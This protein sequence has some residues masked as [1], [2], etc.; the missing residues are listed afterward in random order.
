VIESREV[1]VLAPDTTVGDAVDRVVASS[2]PALPVAGADGRYRGMFGEREL[3]VALFPAYVN[4]LGYAAFVPK[5]LEAAL[6][7][8]RG[9]LGDPVERHMNREH[10]DV[11]ADFSDLQLAEIFIHHRVLIVPV[12]D[13]GRVVG[14]VTRT[15]FFRALIDSPA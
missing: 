3:I 6:E 15:D 13:G 1:D 11:V 14:V 4:N 7:K 8:R 9:C 5:S 2:L 10:V 12:T